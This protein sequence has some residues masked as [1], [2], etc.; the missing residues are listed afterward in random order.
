MIKLQPQGSERKRNKELTKPLTRVMIES[1]DE[2]FSVKKPVKKIE[3]PK[4]FNSKKGKRL[5][6]KRFLIGSF[7]MSLWF[8]LVVPRRGHVRMCV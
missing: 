3:N 2:G 6:K 1:N 4:D 8:Y 7:D 5:D